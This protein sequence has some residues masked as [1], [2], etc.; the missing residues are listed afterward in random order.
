MTQFG[1]TPQQQILLN[2]IAWHIATHGIAPSYAEM[3]AATGHTSKSAVHRLLGAL[4]ER[5][6]IER[7]ENRNRAIRIVD[8]SEIRTADAIRVVLDRCAVSPLMA[9]MLRRLLEAETA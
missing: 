8:T 5:G 3:C 1:L 4:E 6:Y 7:L 9:E 2:Y